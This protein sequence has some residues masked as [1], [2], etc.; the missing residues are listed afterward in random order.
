L[1]WSESGRA[2]GGGLLDD[3]RLRRERLNKWS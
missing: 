1:A 2:S 3:A